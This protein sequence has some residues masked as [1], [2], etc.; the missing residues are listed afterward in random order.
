MTDSSSLGLFQAEQSLFGDTEMIRKEHFGT[1][2]RLD[3]FFRL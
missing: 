2:N 3:N 1:R